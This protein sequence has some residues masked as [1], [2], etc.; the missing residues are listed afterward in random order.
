MVG[1]DALCCRQ[2]RPVPPESPVA[3]H[4]TTGPDLVA[5]QQ[6]HTAREGGAQ[7]QGSRSPGN[8]CLLLGQRIK[9]LESSPSAL[10]E[11]KEEDGQESRKTRC[12]PRKAT[13]FSPKQ[14]TLLFA[15]KGHEV[16]FPGDF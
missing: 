7:A 3:I 11:V 12:E 9:E 5:L 10:W 2:V 13:V 6:R 1:P 16:F 15:G 8:L 14:E 4:L